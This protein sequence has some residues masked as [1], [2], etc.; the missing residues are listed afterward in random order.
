MTTYHISL[1]RATHYIPYYWTLL[2]KL[3][4]EHCSANNLNVRLDINVKNIANNLIER[5]VNNNI[6]LSTADLDVCKLQNGS[7]ARLKGCQYL[8]IQD[9]I[10]CDNRPGQTPSDCGVKPTN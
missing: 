5:M 7:T 10:K 1:V 3:Q 2:L 8:Y 6:Y 9:V 4:V